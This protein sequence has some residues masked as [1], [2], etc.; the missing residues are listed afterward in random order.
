MS[1]YTIV[2]P[3][4]SSRAGS[5]SLP[6]PRGPQGASRPGQLTDSGPREGSGARGAP[7]SP[8]KNSQGYGSELTQPS[9]LPDR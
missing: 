9:V 3:S 1:R 8:D 2:S 4:S 7:G 6:P 5:C